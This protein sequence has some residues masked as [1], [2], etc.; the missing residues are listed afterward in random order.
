MRKHQQTKHAL[1][2]T[3]YVTLVLPEEVAPDALFNGLWQ[4]IAAFERRFSRFLPDSELTAFNKA[5]G[6]RQP[7][8]TGFRDLLL[9]AR[10]M[11]EKTNGLYNPFVLPAL[12]RAGYKGSWPQPDRVDARLNYEKRQGAAGQDIEIGDS[13]AAIPAYTA[14]D[15]G[16]IGKGYLLDELS[17][18]LQ[19]QQLT[20]YWLSLGGDILCSGVDELDRAWEVGIQDALREG[21]AV[22]RVTNQGGQLAIATS[23][24]TKRKGV[25]VHGSWHHIIDPRTNLPADTDMLTA[26]VCCASAT[27]ADVYAKC[28]VIT[29]SHAVPNFMKMLKLDNAL[30][31]YSEDGEGVILRKLGEIWLV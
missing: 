21:V 31:Q 25:S 8:S 11:S 16:G 4:H 19:S 26:T 1:G 2:S 7:V 18:F 24:I 23:G 28:L 10:E 17:R 5:A 6:T 13:W 29:G 27:E 3:A 12:Q 9:A 14:L 22:A 30:L 20:N 15:F